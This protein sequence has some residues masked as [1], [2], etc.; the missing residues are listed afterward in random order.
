[1]AL[2][3]GEQ[4]IIDALNGAFSYFQANLST[5]VP[6]IFGYAT[7]ADQQEIISLWTNYQVAVQGSYPFKAIQSP[8]V[9]VTIEPEEETDQYAGNSQTGVITNNS[10]GHA[11]M[12]RSTYACYC[13]SVNQKAL[14]WLQV[15]VKWALLFQRL[16]LQ[17]GV[18]NGQPTGYFTEQRLKLS[19][20]TPVPEGLGDSIFPFQRTVYLIATHIDTWSD[21]PQT[22]MQ[23]GGIT[24]TV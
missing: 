21:E 23:S 20:L 22:P 6:D 8:Q 17:Q 1:M 18:V 16:S 3:L 7:A 9:S 15:L 14:L 5:L 24:I 10:N 13:F 11:T 12:F 4:P 19:G 2:T